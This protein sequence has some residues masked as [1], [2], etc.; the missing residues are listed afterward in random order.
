MMTG[1][2]K[3]EDMLPLILESLENNGEFVFY[4]K[5]IS[6]L[7]TIVQ[8]KDRVKL[9]KPDCIKKYSIVLY[10]RENGKFV[11]H[12]VVKKPE[13]GVYTMCGDNQCF[14]E[15]GIKS[16]QVIAVVSEILKEN[17]KVVSCLGSFNYF[18]G[19]CIRAYRFPKKV[20]HVLKRGIKKV[21]KLNNR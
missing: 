4:P 18:Y 20:Y 14:S 2:M 16:S 9:V 1:E 19:I 17:D 8:L 12:R 3:M 7:P 11:L 10:R 6:M 21:L 5:G 13:N 15:Y